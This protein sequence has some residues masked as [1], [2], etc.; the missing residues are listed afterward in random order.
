MLAIRIHETGGVEK[1]RGEEIALPSPGP[2]EVR[3]TVE[4]AGLN[5]IDTYKRSGLY[6]VPLP[7]TL[8]QEAAGVVT[9]VAAGVTEFRIGDRVASA[10]ANG[11]YARETIAP[12]TQ[13]VRVPADVTSQ[14]AAAV[15]LQ[16][17]T[18][19]YLACD[20][21]PLKP[22]LRSAPPVAP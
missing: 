8:G 22:G 21:F 10:A 14:L 16:G 19:H 13:T 5:F 11:A 1:L 9:A 7:H 6:A 15:M 4:A 3:F 17:M 20:T 12:V 18:A 2:G